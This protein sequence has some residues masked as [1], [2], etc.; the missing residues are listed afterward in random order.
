[1]PEANETKIIVPEKT[2]PASGYKLHSYTIDPIR[3]LLNV[4]L[5]K[6]D[7]NGER[8]DETMVV[9][10]IDCSEHAMEIN[11]IINSLVAAQLPGA[12]LE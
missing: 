9:S 7:E 8:I 3:N 11:E 12:Q 2:V 6:L 1:M 5:S 4:V 10:S